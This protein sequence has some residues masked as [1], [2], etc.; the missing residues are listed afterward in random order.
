M[1]CWARSAKVVEEKITT[2]LARLAFTGC[3][4]THAWVRRNINT[5]QMLC[6]ITVATTK[7][8]PSKTCRKN[9]MTRISP[10]LWK[11]AVP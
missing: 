2:K 10:F 11:A 9:V 1:A 5:M 8:E 4:F 3:R 7:I 6:T